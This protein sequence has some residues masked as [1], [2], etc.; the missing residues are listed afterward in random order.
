MLEDIGCSCWKG[1]CELNG[2]GGGDES[3]EAKPL[4]PTPL[5][6][7]VTKRRGLNWDVASFSPR[8]ESNAAE[9]FRGMRP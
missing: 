4:D 1:S 6:I 9:L 7:F 5:E 2:G 8:S 3:L